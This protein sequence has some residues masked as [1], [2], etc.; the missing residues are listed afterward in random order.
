MHK[1]LLWLARLGLPLAGAC[2]L[3]SPVD[4]PAPDVAGALRASFQAHGQA[5]M[6][7]LEQDPLQAFCSRPQ[8]ERLA[9]ADLARRLEDAERNA[10]S[11]PA[12]GRLI[13]NWRAGEKIAQSGTGLQYSDDPGR[14]SGGNCYAC[15]ALRSDEVAYGT[16]GPSLVHYGVTHGSDAS[17]QRAAF[18]RIYD[19]KAFMACSLMPRFG[20]KGILTEE[21]I[22][23]LVGLLL[24]PDS[25]VNR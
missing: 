5:G 23:D 9:A 7:R 3:Q 16:L 15:H 4:G 6:A 18:M 12:D 22:K 10:I 2:T 1:A 20:R 14:P 8:G 24:D 19:A 21:Q 25:P 13:G 11:L 17:A